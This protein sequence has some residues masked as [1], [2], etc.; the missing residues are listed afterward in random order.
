MA[1]MEDLGRKDPE[2]DIMNEQELDNEYVNITHDHLNL[3]HDD[4]DDD[5]SDKL[6]VVKEK[7]NYIE[8]I[9]ENKLGETTFTIITRGSKRSYSAP[10]VEFVDKRKS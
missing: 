9:L 1:E 5:N 3:L 2:Y 8:H 10:E 6:N 7:I 4:D